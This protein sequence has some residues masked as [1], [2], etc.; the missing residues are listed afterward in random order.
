M[1]ERERKIG[2][3]EALYRT[4]NERIDDL[5]QVF[6][7]ITNTMTVVC[8]CGDGACAQ[9]IELA[10]GDYERVRSESTNFIIVP[11]HEIPDVEDVV[12]RN[13][14]FDVVRKHAG[15]IAELARETDPRAR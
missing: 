8:E 2:E 11:G 15:D 12:E 7:T 14:T 9:Q 10:V 5:N 1:D 13:D 4:V 6:G 3:N